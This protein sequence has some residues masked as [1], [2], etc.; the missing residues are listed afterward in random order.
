MSLESHHLG[1]GG[2]DNSFQSVPCSEVLPLSR[3]LKECDGSPLRSRPG[4]TEADGL[5]QGLSARKDGL[6]VHTQA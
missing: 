4:P 2:E 6:S 1:I 5:T 3:P